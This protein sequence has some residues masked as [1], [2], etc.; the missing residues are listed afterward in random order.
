MHARIVC[1]TTH[2]L[3]QLLSFICQP[4]ERPIPGASKGAELRVL[5]AMHHPCAAAVSGGRL[6]PTPKVSTRN[7]LTHCRECSWEHSMSRQ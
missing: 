2:F 6:V 1:R 7:K 5:Q 3:E 4:D